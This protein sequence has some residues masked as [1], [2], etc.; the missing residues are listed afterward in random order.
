MRVFG[1]ITC[2]VTLSSTLTPRIELDVNRSDPP[3]FCSATS[4]F[5]H[6]HPKTFL[7]LA[8]KT[9]PETVKNHCRSGGEHGIPLQCC[10]CGEMVPE[11]D[12]VVVNFYRFVSVK[13]PLAEVAKHLSFLK[14]RASSLSLPVPFFFLS[15]WDKVFAMQY[16][17]RLLCCKA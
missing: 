15:I 4:I 11:D 14:V 7:F 9:K 13:D 2:G 3:R 17:L 5:S 1:A 16:S 6:G 12:F 8:R 10:K